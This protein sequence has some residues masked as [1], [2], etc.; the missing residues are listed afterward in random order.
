MTESNVAGGRYAG[1]VAT[2]LGEAVHQ[3]DQLTGL[4]W[5][6]HL[7]LDRG[8]SMAT[9]SAGA[10]RRPRAGPGGALWPRGEPAS[11]RTAHDRRAHRGLDGDDTAS[12]VASAATAPAVQL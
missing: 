10:V 7:L 12:S 3:A 11:V 9:R 6:A 8:E 2:A 5:R 1:E 4:L